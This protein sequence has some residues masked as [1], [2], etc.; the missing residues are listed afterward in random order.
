MNYRAHLDR[1]LRLAVLKILNGEAG[2]RLN[3]AALSAVLDGLGYRR[4]RA[5]LH[6][7]LR[8]LQEAG[9]VAIR[10]VDEG[11]IV[12]ATLTQAGRE[13]V[14]ARAMLEG[15]APAEPDE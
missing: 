4:S 10:A 5:N 6:S 12:V 11:H 1:D 13:H 9:G 14:E 8:F 7:H 3:S 2:Y 15:V